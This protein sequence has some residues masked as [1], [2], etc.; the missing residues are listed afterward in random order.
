MPLIVRLH[1]VMQLHRFLEHGA[2]IPIVVTCGTGAALLFQRVQRVQQR[3]ARH[4]G[5]IAAARRIRHV[6]VIAQGDHDDIGE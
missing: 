4:Q 3:F 6:D 2:D 5:A 1:A